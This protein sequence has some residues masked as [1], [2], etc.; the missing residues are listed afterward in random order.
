ML[1]I[2]CLVYNKYFYVCGVCMPFVLSEHIIHMFKFGDG[3]W[4]QIY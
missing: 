3:M 1:L 2:C 4:A